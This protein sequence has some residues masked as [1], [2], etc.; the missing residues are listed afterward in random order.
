MP[1]PE[2]RISL[3]GITV[4]NWE[5]CINLQLPEE[6]CRLVASNLYSLAEAYVQPSL[7]P[8]AIYDGEQLV[9]FVMYQRSEDDS[10]IW[11]PRFMIGAAHQGRGMG[12]RAMKA[13]LDEVRSHWPESPILLSLTPENRA[14]RRLYLSLGFV[15]TG[16]HKQGEDILALYPD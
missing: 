5:E 1:K 11:I 15:D 14:A 9:G 4:E 3:R 6:Q 8:R 16:E 10:S 7:H 12:R 13:T 2:D